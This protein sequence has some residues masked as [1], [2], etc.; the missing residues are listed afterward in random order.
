MTG[1]HDAHA[2]AGREG[3]DVLDHREL[4]PAIG[5]LEAARS[6]DSTSAPLEKARPAPVTIAHQMS[7]RP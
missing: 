5:L 7:G 6:S 2:A 3:A 1:F 4:A